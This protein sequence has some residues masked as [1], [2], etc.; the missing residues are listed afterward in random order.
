M[1]CAADPR[2]A[3]ATGRRRSG[4]VLSSGL[5]KGGGIHPPSPRPPRRRA[6]HR[7]GRPRPGKTC[8]PLLRMKN[9]RL[10]VRARPC[11][12]KAGLPRDGKQLRFAAAAIPSGAPRP[13]RQARGM[14]RRL[15]HS[16]AGRTGLCLRR[17]QH[18]ERA[19]GWQRISRAAQQDNPARGQDDGTVRHAAAMA[20]PDA[21]LEGDQLCHDPWIEDPQIPGQPVTRRGVDHHLAAHNGMEKAPADWRRACLRAPAPRRQRDLR[22]GRGMIAENLPVFRSLPVARPSGA[23]RVMSRASDR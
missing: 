6:I 2:A 15:P 18:T 16:V 20:P 1:P 21:E 11:A 22:T 8:E 7:R 19:G 12:G 14:A 5:M 3:P 17:N 9:A 10:R 23:L 13:V 4:R